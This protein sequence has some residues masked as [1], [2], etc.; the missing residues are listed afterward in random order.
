MRLI[1]ISFSMQERTSGWYIVTVEKWD[2]GKIHSYDHS[3][4]HPNADAAHVA[5]IGFIAH[6]AVA[7]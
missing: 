3:G 1:S 6:P 5:M 7:E 2:D 4:P